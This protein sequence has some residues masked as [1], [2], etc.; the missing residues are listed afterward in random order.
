MV[1]KSINYHYHCLKSQPSTAP[2]TSLA[3]CHICRCSAARCWVLVILL[4]LFQFVLYCIV[5]ASQVDMT[6]R[7]FRRV[8]SPN[9]SQFGLFLMDE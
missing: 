1:K 7:V 2:R 5:A 6:Q 4:F 3:I 8:K 9:R